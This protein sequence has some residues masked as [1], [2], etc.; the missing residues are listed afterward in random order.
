MNRT[1]FVDYVAHMVEISCLVQHKSKI[2]VIFGLEV[3][4]VNRDDIDRHDKKIVT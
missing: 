2:A 4:C 1:G 3:F